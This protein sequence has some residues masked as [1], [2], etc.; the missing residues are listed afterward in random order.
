MCPNAES[1][2]NEC[3]L[4]PHDDREGGLDMI[5][6][7]AMALGILAFVATGTAHAQGNACAGAKLKAAGGKAACLLGLESGESKKAVTG[8]PLKFQKCRDKESSSFAKSE[9]KALSSGTPCSAGN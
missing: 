4:S 5:G 2:T 9:A 6:R 3:G 8:D 1:R 7:L